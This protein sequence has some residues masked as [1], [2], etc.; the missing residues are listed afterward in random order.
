MNLPE[1]YRELQKLAGEV[2][3]ASGKGKKEEII[4]SLEDAPED[5]VKEALEKQKT[6]SE[7]SETSENEEKGESD[8]PGQGNDPE[9]NQENTAEVSETPEN[10]KKPELEYSSDR[11]HQGD[12]LGREDPE[13]EILEQAEN[14]ETED[15]ETDYSS[16]GDEKEK[17][18]DAETP[19]T[20]ETVEPVEFEPDVFKYPHILLNQVLQIA[21]GRKFGL[22]VPDLTAEDLDDLNRNTQ[23]VA[24]DKLSPRQQRR[25]QGNSGIVGIIVGHGKKILEGMVTEK[26]EEEEDQG[27]QEDNSTPEH[28][29]Q[30]QEEDQ[31]DGDEPKFGGF[32]P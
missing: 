6:D 4:Q 27:D 26:V 32:Q 31:E 22:E 14:K 2:S 19:E 9:D 12:L 11:G 29:R 10:S 7:V 28:L 8:Q 20:T 23:I 25:L 5:Q 17:E 24:E 16:Q 30:D 15:G 3:E 13:A 1:N 21:L 18:T